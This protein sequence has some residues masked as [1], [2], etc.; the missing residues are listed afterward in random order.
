MYKC[1]FSSSSYGFALKNLDA[2]FSVVN[3]ECMSDTCD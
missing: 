3:I 2:T 1:T